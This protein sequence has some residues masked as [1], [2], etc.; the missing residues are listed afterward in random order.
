MFKDNEIVMVCIVCVLEIICGIVKSSRMYGMVYVNN[1]DN[2]RR[3]IWMVF[4]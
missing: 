3:N 4:L 1:V 2:I